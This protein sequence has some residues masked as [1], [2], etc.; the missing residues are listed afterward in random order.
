MIAFIEMCA[1]HYLRKTSSCS[2]FSW[3]LGSSRAGSIALSNIHL[4]AAVRNYFRG[5]VD[6]EEWRFLLTGGV[7]LDNP[8]PNPAPD[9]LP[10]KSWAEIVR[11]SELK[12]FNRFMDDFKGLV[13]CCYQLLCPCGHQCHLFV[14]EV[15]AVE[16]RL[17]RCQ[18]SPGE[19]AWAM[20]DQT[21]PIA[22]TCS[23]TVSTT[24]QGNFI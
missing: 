5:K 12:S 6:E 15:V 24:R 13:S 8:H 16:S 22:E 18:S 2:H 9:W 7:A 19:D 4:L 21:K 3:L 10:D 20:A 11:C 23:S 17:W 1:G 14:S